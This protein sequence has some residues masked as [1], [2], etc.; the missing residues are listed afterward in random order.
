MNSLKPLRW[1]DVYNA[2]VWI[3]VDGIGTNDPAP[4]NLD[5][6]LYDDPLNLLVHA[7]RI[8]I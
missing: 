8:K 1:Y 6:C 4:F 2:L 3:M 7:R 5:S